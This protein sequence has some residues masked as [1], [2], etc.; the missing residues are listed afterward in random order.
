MPTVIR[1]RGVGK[2]FLSG[3]HAY[4]RSV[5]RALGETLTGR[6]GRREIWALRGVDLDV[7]AGEAVAVVGPNGAG[8][9]TLLLL[10]AGILEKSEGELSVTA[11]ANLFFPF[12]ATLQPRLTVRRNF[13]L[14]S[15]LLGLP[16]ERFRKKFEEIIHFSGLEERLEDRLGEL[17]TGLA[18]RVAFSVAV[19]V[20]QEIVLADEMLAVGDMAFQARCRAALE[21]LRRGGAT[22]VLAT[23]DMA[24]A[25]AMC[26]SAIYIGGGR[27]RL[28]GSADAVVRRFEE[29]SRG[30]AWTPS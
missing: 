9:S 10:L 16:R 29:D 25:Q 30:G 12:G 23:H 19:H 3:S 7:S 28:A 2:R 26:P 24:V 5:L 21:R 8:K 20:E 1:A 18:A 14:A 15:A 6:D 22:L 13:D 17:S 11:R 27:V 4:R